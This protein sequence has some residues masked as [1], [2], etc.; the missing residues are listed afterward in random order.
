MP[1]IEIDHRD[2]L[3]CLEAAAFGPF[4]I[5]RRDYLTQGGVAGQLSLIRRINAK[6]K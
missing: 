4:S 5:D 6:R 2:R 3:D 1:A